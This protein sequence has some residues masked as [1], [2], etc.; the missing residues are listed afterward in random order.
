[1]ATFLK[2]SVVTPS[3]NQGIFLEQ[4]I[5]SVIGQNYPALEYIVID[6]GSKDES[7]NILAKHDKSLAYWVCEPDLGQS[8]AINKGFAK[9][10][11]DILLW[12]NSDDM[13]LP[14]ALHIINEQVK[15]NGNGIYFGN[16]IHFREAINLTSWGSNVIETSRNY[17]LIDLD[18]II[19]PSSFWT[20]NVVNQVGSLSETLHFGFDWEWFIRA[21]M[22]GIPFFPLSYAVSLYRF[23]DNHKTGQ[24]GMKRQEELL[25]IIAKYNPQKAGLFELI[26]NEQKK[27]TS[28]PY[29]LQTL[30]LRFIG[31][32]L[33]YGHFLKVSK[34]WK[35]KKYSAKDINGFAD[36]L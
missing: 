21:E 18:F 16:C 32:P 2:I 7:P 24:G 36:M 11:G 35:Y 22:L 8:N 3:F 28:E 23:H 17:K 13:L 14:N 25:S 29:I 19:Q 4:T 1:M 27:R 15:A 20:R 12:L 30:F 34:Y 5:N 31:K 33:S 6:G 10:T 9:S 26:M